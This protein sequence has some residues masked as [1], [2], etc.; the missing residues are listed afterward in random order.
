MKPGNRPPA[1]SDNPVRRW[2][3]KTF[4]ADYFRRVA[5]T[6][7]MCLTIYLVYLLVTN[8]PVDLAVLGIFIPTSGVSQVFFRQDKPL[9]K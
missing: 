1:L 9:K 7:T 6:L 8:G 5:F 3:Q 2:L 4:N